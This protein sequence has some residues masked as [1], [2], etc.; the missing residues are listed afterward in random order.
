M[1]ALAIL[2]KRESGRIVRVTG[3][4]ITINEKRSGRR[5]VVELKRK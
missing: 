5:D 4:N 3:I 2:E 1:S